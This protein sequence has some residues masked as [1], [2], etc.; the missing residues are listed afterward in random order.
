MRV[1]GA[2]IADIFAKTTG[3]DGDFVVKVIDV[4]PAENASDPK[5]GGYE[6]PISLDIFRSRYRQSFAKPAAIPAV[7]CRNTILTC[8]SWITCF[9]RATRS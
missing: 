2:P 5:M 9:S 1:S 7:R 6:L 4:G 8:R 3:A